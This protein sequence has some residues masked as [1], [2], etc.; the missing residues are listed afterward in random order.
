MK[1]K[2]KRR[3]KE[4]MS[5][6]TPSWKLRVEED[7]SDDET[8]SENKSKNRPQITDYSIPRPEN[9]VKLISSKRLKTFEEAKDRF[10][11]Q[12]HRV[13]AEYGDAND[14]NSYAVLV[15]DTRCW[16]VRFDDGDSLDVP[17]TC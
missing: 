1:G 17:V 15:G 10:L 6:D 7:S 3:Q 12:N 11:V 8:P 2:K 14:Y 13:L 16:N 4:L 9:H 5:F